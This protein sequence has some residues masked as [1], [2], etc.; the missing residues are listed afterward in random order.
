M[1]VGFRTFRVRESTAVSEA[2]RDAAL[3]WMD[4]C[5]CRDKSHYGPCT[6]RPGCSS[7]TGPLIEPAAIVL[8]G[9]RPD[10]LHADVA[11]ENGPASM[12]LT[13]PEVRERS[14][15][16]VGADAPPGSRSGRRGCISTSMSSMNARC[17][18]SDTR[19]R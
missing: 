2:D 18:P 6:D 3:M 4:P 13:A 17:P 16:S 8:L 14:A 12:P 5:G 19:N 10:E 9:N 7:E 1:A 11:R 15:A